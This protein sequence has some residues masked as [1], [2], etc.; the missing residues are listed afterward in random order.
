MPDFDY[1]RYKGPQ[2]V[3]DMYRSGY[4]EPI[5]PAMTTH[6]EAMRLYPNKM[7]VGD[8]PRGFY[9]DGDVYNTPDPVFLG[10]G[11]E[12][13]PIEFE[14]SERGRGMLA[15]PQPRPQPMPM[16]QQ[17]P[18]ISP[19]EEEMMRRQQVE[20][21]MRILGSRGMLGR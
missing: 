18:Q 8:M 13:D 9:E 2:T 21:M 3:Q 20:D 12:D 5:P 4:A 14:I 7:P 11:T 1:R 10:S 16:P 19:Y 6:E 17:A 15:P